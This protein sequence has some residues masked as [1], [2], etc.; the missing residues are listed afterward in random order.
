MPIEID[1]VTTEISLPDRN[2]L[3]S[4]RQMEQI[5]REVF[6]R[7]NDKQREDRQADDASSFG[8]RATG[9]SS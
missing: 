8:G 4:P 9:R 2:A 1:A 7:L 6:R 5:V 3:L